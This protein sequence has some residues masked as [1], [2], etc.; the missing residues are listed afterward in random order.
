MAKIFKNG[1]MYGG[2][3]TS[4]AYDVAIESAGIPLLENVTNVQSAIKILA[5][6]VSTNNTDIIQIKSDIKK[7]QADIAEIKE[8]LKQ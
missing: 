1:I 5:N 6:Q 2:Y 7:L 4:P 3:Y 8:L